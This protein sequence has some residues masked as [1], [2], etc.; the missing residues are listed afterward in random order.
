MED[1]SKR[2]IR[3]E[4][5]DITMTTGCNRENIKEDFSFSYELVWMTVDDLL[6][7]RRH[8]SFRLPSWHVLQ[9]GR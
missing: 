2:A 3:E 5:R 6:S 4:W 9:R 8:E 7:L 1:N